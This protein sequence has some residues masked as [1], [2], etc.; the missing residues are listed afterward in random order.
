MERDGAAARGL[1]RSFDTDDFEQFDV[2]VRDWNLETTFLEKGPFRGGAH[3]VATGAAAI[4]HG[5]FR[6]AVR[7]RGDPPPGMRTV[8][9]TA[10][11]GQHFHW[12]GVLATD[13]HI[14]VH[15]AGGEV[16][17]HTSSRLDILTISLHESALRAAADRTQSRGLDDAARG[18]E[19][20]RVSA[21]ALAPLRAA[22]LSVVR[23]A[24]GDPAVL[25]DD[26]VGTTLSEELPEL[27]LGALSESSG[28]AR[29]SQRTRL[30]LD[31]VRHVQRSADAAP[32]VA[33]L[34]AALDTSE[35]TLRRAFV[36]HCS[37]SPQQ[38]ILR[39]RLHCVRQALLR[40]GSATVSAVANRWG[41]WHMGEF[42]AH[43]RSVFGE[44][45]SETLAAAR[46]RRVG[47]NLV[48]LSR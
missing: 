44:L 41:F 25:A 24:V 27:V 23:R 18:D 12:R 20:V 16:D 28:R 36:E 17:G 3:Q 34:S 1:A 15:P 2:L 38:Y 22:A 5:W 46:T 48:V 47:G 43:Y 19:L 31:A 29:R 14:V 45:P 39:W 35:R 32:T 30:F 4:S 9:L 37:V 8:L 26:D 42:A 33:E 10:V 11:P 13:E 21:E 7:Q 6:G 40:R